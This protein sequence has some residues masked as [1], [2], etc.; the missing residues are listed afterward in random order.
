MMI[1]IVISVVL[2]VQRFSELLLSRRN[3]GWAMAHG[4][5][6][7]GNDH[8]WL[9]IALH[10]MWIVAIN[11]EWYV[12]RP[13]IP[14]FWPIIAAIL[15]LAQ[16]IRYWAIKTLGKR[17]NTRIVVMP[18]L[19]LVV[20]GPYRFFKHPNY[21]A[22]VLEIAAVPALVGCWYTAIVFSILNAVLLFF[23]RIPA[24]EKALRSRRATG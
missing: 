6:E 13:T 24:E 17:W 2:I 4:A 1:V 12:L 8:Y 11:V 7:Y 15:I 3:I 14:S 22:V 21:L 10:S 23:I 19:P 5:R 16:L 18:D 20:A 9:F